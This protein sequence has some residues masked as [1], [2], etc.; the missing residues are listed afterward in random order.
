[1]G[2]LYKILASKRICNGD[3]ILEF[4]SCFWATHCTCIFCTINDCTVVNLVS[5]PSRDKGILFSF[6]NIIVL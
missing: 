3:I 2:Y 1:M 6:D 5:S 4:E